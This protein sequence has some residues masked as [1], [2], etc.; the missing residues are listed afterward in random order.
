MTGP[1]PADIA[2]DRLRAAPYLVLLLDYDGTLV[3]FAPTPERAAPDAG[4]LSL[5]AQ[6]A[7]R[8]RTEVHIASGRTRQSLAHWLGSLPVWLHAEHGAWSRPP[9]PGEWTGLP[10]PLAHW[11][12]PVRRIMDAFAGRTPG[13]LVEEKTAGLAWHY[14][15]AEP[16]LGAARAL[17]LEHRLRAVLGEGPLEVVPGAMLVEVRPR[18]VHKGRIVGPILARVAPSAVLAALGDDRTDEDMFRAL[19][20]GAVAIRIGDPR[21]SAAALRLPDARAARR[22]LGALLAA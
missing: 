20:P 18:A 12:A 8:P 3:E 1:G 22:F 15:R 11:R 21:P 13:A 5:L 10:L 19:P 17:E 16:A 14:R 9:G 6:L 2:L 7:E 4:A